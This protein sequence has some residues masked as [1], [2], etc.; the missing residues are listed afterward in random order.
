[1]AISVKEALGIKNQKAFEASLGACQ[2]F[3]MPDRAPR[4]TLEWETEKFTLDEARSRAFYNSVDDVRNALLRMM[5]LVG[6]IDFKNPKIVK[7]ALKSYDE[8]YGGLE[9]LKTQEEK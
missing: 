5:F 6:E 4:I 8:L 9:G 7:A 2:A 3:T 1:M